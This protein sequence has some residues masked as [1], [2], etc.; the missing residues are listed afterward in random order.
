MINKKAF[1]IKEVSFLVL[2]LGLALMLLS[3]TSS[4]L[5]SK[6]VQEQA[7]AKQIA[8]MIDSAKPNTTISIDLFSMR[9][10]LMKNTEA[11]QID[12]NN[13]LVLVNFESVQG[14]KF[15]YFTDAKISSKLIEKQYLVIRIE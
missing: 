1:L 9:K 3:F 6:S 7:Y 13:K 12:N 5:N 8:L 14:Y 4:T 15:S 11:I 2:N 10:Y